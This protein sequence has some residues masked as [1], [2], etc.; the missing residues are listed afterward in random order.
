MP[1]A[2]AK[3]EA[4][5]ADSAASTSSSRLKLAT[6]ED[7]ATAVSAASALPA[8][9]AASALLAASAAEAAATARAAELEAAS[10][11]LR[12]EV[13]RT[14][15]QINEL[16]VKLKQVEEERE[17]PLIVYALGGLVLLLS[18][19]LWVLWRQR[20]QGRN[21]SEW[22]VQAASL[23]S[24]T[25][26]ESETSVRGFE[27]VALQT[28][29]I[30]AA[31]ALDDF[32]A[33]SGLGD[34]APLGGLR[35]PDISSAPLRGERRAVSVEELIDLEQ[36]AE[37]FVVLGQD[38]AAVELLTSHLES[39]TEQSPLPYLKLL[40]I[41]KRRGAR[42][43]YEQLRERFNRRFAGHAPDWETGLQ[44][45]RSLED[46]PSIVADLQSL[47][48]SPQRALAVLQ[49]SL[50]R[51]ALEGG[52]ADA[53]H[54]AFDL[55][56]YRELMMLYSVARDLSEANAGGLVDFSLP[57]DG[58]SPSTPA[59]FERL[60]ATTPVAAQPSLAKP[61]TIDLSLDDVESWA[62]ALPPITAPGSKSTP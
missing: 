3:A 16:S 2:V 15:Q 51:P 4:G 8:D 54:Q 11:R 22:L 61:L 43:D 50:L 18:G 27:T 23:N 29:A 6:L 35:L 19:A 46:Y 36:Q 28:P 37:F 7:G 14:Q 33:D 48:S 44:G 25:A 1:P 53:E 13:A 24:S 31:P 20:E 59:T 39:S 60:L 41:F 21:P 5:S 56:A 47:W 32:S 12:A 42:T 10:Q 34:F 26:P 40:D 52:S 17:Q 45:G 62:P 30:S 9:T 58:G 38:E 55:P 49:I 57:L